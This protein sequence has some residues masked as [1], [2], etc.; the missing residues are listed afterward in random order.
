MKFKLIDD[1]KFTKIITSYCE[2]KY[3]SFQSRK[4]I[5]LVHNCNTNNIK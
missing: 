4:N 2:T 5:K 1:K 3:L